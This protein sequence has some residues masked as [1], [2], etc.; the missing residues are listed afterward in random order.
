[1]GTGNQTEGL[2]KTGLREIPVSRFSLE[3]ASYLVDAVF[4]VYEYF[5]NHAFFINVKNNCP[6]A[7][8]F[9]GD[10]HIEPR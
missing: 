7:L 4:I 1:M 3:T 2:K 9:V 6:Y 8:F 10:L 5:L